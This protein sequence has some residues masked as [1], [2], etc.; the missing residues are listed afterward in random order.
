MKNFKNYYLLTYVMLIGVVFTGCNIN[1]VDE[2]SPTGD[3]SISFQSTST[4]FDLTDA[5]GE[6]VFDVV[7]SSVTAADYDRTIIISVDENSTS[8][9]T[10]YSFTGNIVIPAGEVTAK[11]ALTINAD[12]VSINSLKTLTL[13]LDESS[14]DITYEKFC[15][16][17]HI[18]LN[19]NFD[20]YGSETSWDITDNSDNS[21]VFSGGP[22]SNSDTSYQEIMTLLDGEYTFTIYD[23]YSDG[24][25]CDYG[26]GSYTLD[27][28]GCDLNIVTGGDFDTSESTTFSIP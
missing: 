20:Y 23:A 4:Y 27:L 21:I 19:I 14:I 5:T 11:T 26:D 1:S 15:V 2:V 24:I 25:C 16:T 17:N 6:F 8:S 9:A 7:I 28:F 18:I 12:V 22:Y 13:V 3:L 10:E